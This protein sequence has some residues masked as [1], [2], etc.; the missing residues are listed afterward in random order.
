MYRYKRIASHLE[1]LYA[2]GHS[3]NGR[4]GLG[5]AD[6]EGVPDAQRA[7]MPVPQPL[8]RLEPIRLVSCGTDFTLA[9]G[10]SNR[11]DGRSCFYSCNGLLAYLHMHVGASGAWAWGNGA[12]GRLGTGDQKDRYD[13]V[14]IP[15]LRGKCVL[16]VSAGAWHSLALVAY[17]PMLG[18][19]AV[20]NEQ[21]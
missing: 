13:P 8:P 1:Q 6:R 14:G 19:G 21:L 20:R 11:Y 18:G 16:S 10:E 9:V 2:W 12:G 4:L 3:G 7:F 15:K 5:A 17:P